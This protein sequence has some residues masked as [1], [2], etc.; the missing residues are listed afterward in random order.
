MN[1]NN[2]NQTEPINTQ[3]E[4]NGVQAEKTFTQDEVNKIVSD[5][6]A[7]ERSK[8]EQVKSDE[9]AQR[10]AELTARENKLICKE[11]LMDN[12]YP[13][14]M[15]DCMDTSDPEKF[16]NNAKSIFNSICNKTQRQPLPAPLYSDGRAS[17]APRFVQSDYM[18]A[19]SEEVFRNAQK[20]TPKR[21]YPGNDY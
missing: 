17:G 9:D 5:R 6:L 16:K 2:V 1:E 7:K 11:Y 10:A 15:L 4:D 20:H 8:A 13:M 14:E 3:P 21:K 19:V 12:N 18:A